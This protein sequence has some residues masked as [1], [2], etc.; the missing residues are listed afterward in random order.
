MNGTPTA[1]PADDAVDAVVPSVKPPAVYPEV[2]VPMSVP[3]ADAVDSVEFS[4]SFIA[5]AAN[6]VN[7]PGIPAAPV[8]VSAFRTLLI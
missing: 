4:R 7:D 2:C 8:G 5:D 6:A 3:A 1:L